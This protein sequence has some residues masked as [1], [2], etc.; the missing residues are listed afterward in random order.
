VGPLKLRIQHASD[1]PIGITQV[2]VDGRVAGLEFEAGV[3][4]AGTMAGMGAS[5]SR[6][7]GAAGT[8]RSA[9]TRGFPSSPPTSAARDWARC[10]AV[11]NRETYAW[12][13]KR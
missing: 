5:G 6:D 1:L 10:D 11:S 9:S 7:L 12:R 4:T 8:R 13:R 2:V 3:Q